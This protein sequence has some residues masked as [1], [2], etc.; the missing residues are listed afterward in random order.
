M[1]PSLFNIL[2]CAILIASLFIENLLNQT[3]FTI[4]LAII[5][6]F[7][8]VS[9]MAALIRKKSA[10]QKINILKEILKSL[11][12][13]SDNLDLNKNLRLIVDEVGKIKQKMMALQNHNEFL[14][15][16]L[17]DNAKQLKNINAV[18]SYTND[19]NLNQIKEL[20]EKHNEDNI[21]NIYSLTK[22]T[23]TYETNYDNFDNELNP[24][25]EGAKIAILN[26]DLLENFLLETLLN[27]YG[28]SVDFYTKI[29]DFSNYACV[30]A[31]EN[32]NYKEKNTIILSENCNKDSFL[33]R[34]FNKNKLKNILV[35]MLNDYKSDMNTTNY[36]NDVLILLS[37]DMQS[38]YLYHIANKHAKLNK[39]VDSISSF[40]DELKNNYKII[41]IG[42]EAILFD[43]E[44][45]VS[46]INQVKSENPNTFI[47]LFL[48]NKHAKKNLDFADLIIKDATE[49]QIAEVMKKYL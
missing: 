47:M 43:Y 21:Q 2:L 3:I 23:I 38:D 18:L 26:N 20:I 14:H 35:T 17:I 8:A 19:K 39:K 44:S 24:N 7:N 49:T 29:N 11:G 30:I 37:S 4:I 22:T 42:Y 33:K 36:Q 15:K 9:F 40:K 12:A 32:F 6:I 45:L 48:G 31:D 16:H 10:N 5:L 46:N 41:A 25:F 28:I 1:F 34:P 13:N 27:Q